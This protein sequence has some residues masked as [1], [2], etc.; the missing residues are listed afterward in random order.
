MV[1]ERILKGRPN[2]N[3]ERW[4]MQERGKRKQKQRKGNEKL[5]NEEK[6]EKS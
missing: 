4:K 1:C 5:E 2:R 3:E 6:K